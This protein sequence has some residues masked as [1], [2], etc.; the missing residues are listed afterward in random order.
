MV[1]IFVVIVVLVVGI[2]V[3]VVVVVVGFVVVGV[4]LVLVVVVVDA[5]VVVVAVVVLVVVDEVVDVVCVWVIDLAVVDAEENFLEKKMRLGYFKYI[6]LLIFFT[7]TNAVIYLYI[8][9]AFFFIMFLIQLE[10]LN[11]ST[12]IELCVDQ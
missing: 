6:C 2:V 1:G 7:N 10:Y 9:P 11:T 8:L 5:V 12:Y 4:V 3:V